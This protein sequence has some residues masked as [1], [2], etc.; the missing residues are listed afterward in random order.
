MPIRRTL[1][2]TSGSTGRKPAVSRRN[3][4]YC[5][6]CNI[7][8]Y[9]P[10]ANA[11]GQAVDL[12]AELGATD[13]VDPTS[14]APPGAVTAIPGGAGVDPAIEAVGAPDPA[15]Q[16]V[17]LLAPGGHAVLVGMMPAG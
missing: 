7:V 5:V 3:V 1:C 12:A 14:P 8:A 16:A 13:T 15:V 2:C 4:G 10:T 6:R 11:A 9:P 17:A